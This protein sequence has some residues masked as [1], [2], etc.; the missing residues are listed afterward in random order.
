MFSGRFPY[1]QGKLLRS[2]CYGLFQWPE[3]YSLPDQEAET[4]MDTLVE[5]M[6][7]RTLRGRRV[8]ALSWTVTG[9]GPA[10]S[11]FCQE[12]G[13]LLYIRTGWLPTGTQLLH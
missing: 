5:G 1:R 3:A 10:G 8:D 7:S 6:F 13:R 2:H 9:W 12:D 11:N 4:I